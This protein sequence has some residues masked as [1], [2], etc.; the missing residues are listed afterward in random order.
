V[1]GSYESR[2]ANTRMYLTRLTP[3][4]R[5]GSASSSVPF[6][7]VLFRQP[8]CTIGR[9]LEDGDV[10]EALGGLQV[11]HTPGHTP[12]SICLYDPQRRALLCGD[13]LFNKNPMTGKEELQL[14]IPLLTWDRAQVLESIRKL[15]TLPVEVLCCGHG[16]PIRQGGGERIRALLGGKV[17]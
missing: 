17:D 10:I 7:R 2:R 8:P 1:F 4:P 14:S 3:R 12:G 16:Q 13:T 9:S 11:I 15:S 5:E 6:D